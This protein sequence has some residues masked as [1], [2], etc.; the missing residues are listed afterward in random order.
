M[1]INQSIR[2]ELAGVD[3]SSRFVLGLGLLTAFALL[4]VW[5]VISYEIFHGRTTALQTVKESSEQLARGLAAYAD[6]SFSLIE[7]RLEVLEL[8]LPPCDGTARFDKE[9]SSR[10]AEMV[11]HGDMLFSAEL[12]DAEGWACQSAR[13]EAALTFSLADQ[14]YFKNLRQD[15]QRAFA[16]GLPRLDPTTGNWLLPIAK[17][18]W[19]LQGTFQ[20]V[21]LATIELQQLN[22]FFSPFDLQAGATLELVHEEG[23]MVARAPFAAELMGRSF[24]HGPLFSHLKQAPRGSYETHTVTDGQ[25]RIITYQSL[26]HRPLLAVVG[27]ATDVVLAPWRYSLLEHVAVGLFFSVIILLLTGMLIWLHRQRDLAAQARLGAQSRM[28]EVILFTAPTPLVFLDHDLKIDQFNQAF[29]D[30]LQQPPAFLEHRDFLYFLDQ[31]GRDQFDAILQAALTGYVTTDHEL[32]AT[33][34]DRGPRTLLL[35]T[36]PHRDLDD[37]VTGVM[38]ALTDISRRKEMEREQNRIMALLEESNADLNQFAYVASHDLRE[39]MR[40]VASYVSLLERNYAKQLDAS[41]REYIA[42]AREGAVRLDQLV[43]DLLQYA[44]VGHTP[45]SNSPLSLAAILNQVM[46]SLGPQIEAT[47]ATLRLPDIYPTLTCHFDEMVQLFENL[48]DNALKFRHPDRA[49]RI[50]LTISRRDRD[51]LFQ[52]QDNGIGIDPAYH[53]KVFVIFQRLHMREKFEG[54]GL[55]LAICRKIVSRHGGR[56]WIDPEFTQGSRICFTL[57][58]S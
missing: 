13:P 23:Y 52:V 48:F 31:E 12:I 50:E 45:M 32:T 6:R 18:R 24:A 25:H 29:C 1:S 53:D 2:E 56:I 8:S 38:V 44:R 47:A 34:K 26:E 36:A 21:I 22:R 42:Y 28:N 46:G 41:G 30:L 4:V 14:P 43:K 54:T 57:P 35:A 40:M 15:R 37:R 16:F 10:L 27:Q 9:V 7:A 19:S 49:L 11:R 17:S 20:G 3:S 55:G 51:W 58:M 5:S 33:F 39:P